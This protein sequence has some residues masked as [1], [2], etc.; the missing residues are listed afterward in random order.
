M[1]GF[2]NYEELFAQSIELSEPCYVERAEF[3]EDSNTEH[4]PRL[5]RLE[6]GGTDVYAVL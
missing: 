4:I 1:T 6:L 3:E 5:A 2:I